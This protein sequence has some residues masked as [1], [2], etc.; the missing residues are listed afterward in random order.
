MIAAAKPTC[1]CCGAII[2]EQSTESN[3]AFDY[4]DFVFT[5]GT[6]RQVYAESGEVICETR[7]ANCK[8]NTGTIDAPQVRTRY[9]SRL[10]R[11]AGVAAMDKLIG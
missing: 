5:C 2:R 3:A 8:A 6:Q 1:P 7:S 9:G 4:I 11:A 10:L